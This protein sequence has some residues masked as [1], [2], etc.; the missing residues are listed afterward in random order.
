MAF[1]GQGFET[2]QVITAVADADL[3][4]ML[5]HAVALTATGI[6]LASTGGGHGI[7]LNKP[8]LGVQGSVCLHGKIHAYVD[9]TTAIVAGDP[10]KSDASGHLVKATTAHDRAVAIALEPKATGLGLIKVLVHAHSI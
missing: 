1:K 5:G 6:A 3:S 9:G 8:T 4:L 2:Q 10:L 7:L